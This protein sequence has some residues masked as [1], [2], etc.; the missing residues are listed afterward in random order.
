MKNFIKRFSKF[1]CLALAIL[2]CLSIVGCKPQDVV[3]DEYTY[4][5]TE[6]YPDNNPDLYFNGTH[7]FTAPVIE[8]EWL[9][10]NGKTDYV[11][12]FPADTVEA[13]KTYYQYYMNEFVYLW[14]KATG[15]VPTIVKD[16]E[17]PDGGVHKE[18]TKYISVGNTSLFKS[19]RTEG[20]ETDKT[21]NNTKVALDRVGGRVKLIDNNLYIIGYCDTGTLSAVYSFFQLTFNYQV[22]SSNTIKIDENVT[23][24]KLR[25]YDITDIPDI[26]Y[27]P[28][29]GYEKPNFYL[30][31]NY[32]RT[33]THSTYDAQMYGPRLRAFR[34]GD[35]IIREILPD[36]YDGKIEEAIQA[37]NDGTLK[38]GT[39]S[40]HNS[41]DVVRA[42]K[43]GAKHSDWFMTGNLQLCYST[44]GNEEEFEAL[45][46][47]VADA[48]IMAFMLNPTEQY[49]MTYGV[50]FTCFDDP[51]MCQCD[52]CQIL[53]KS[54]TD[55]GIITRFTNR[56]CEKV[57]AWIELPENAAYYRD[58]WYIMNAAYLTTQQPSV[59]YNA[60]TE[61]WEP[62][63][64]TVV[65]CE[66]VIIEFC[67]GATDYQQSL[68]AAENKWVKDMMDGWSALTKRI[69][70]FHYLNYTRNPN[71][72][73][74]NF[75]FVS[76]K[77][78]N[79]QI[80]GVGNEYYYSETIHGE[81][82]T[83]WGALLSFINGMLCYNSVLDSGKL[84]DAWFK[85]VYG[86]A[87]NVMYGFFNSQRI[88]NH[89]Q[90]LKHDNYKRASNNT[91]I[92]MIYDWSVSVLDNW[93]NQCQSA[94][95]AVEYLKEIDAEEYDRICYN[96]AIERH[97]IVY[98]MFHQFK[99]TLT[100][101][102]YNTYKSMLSE[103]LDRWPEYEFT[104]AGMGTTMLDWFKTI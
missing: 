66:N 97:S 62:V 74:D 15:F 33:Y 51:K 92:D 29:S 10:K 57:R 24:L 86:P 77:D 32:Q 40:G 94:M 30:R 9:I 37:L 31:R 47:K 34:Q 90:T 23:N 36:E 1:L 98:I 41:M 87:A 65:P 69:T 26:L 44:K 11:L 48:A 19:V 12:V 38:I 42:D 54:Y 56:V 2:M 21:I 16:T 52:N 73:Y 96:I 93:I 4:L 101:E 25:D 27:A 17:L 3:V 95:D 55:S 6:L 78:I 67:P 104:H 100:S 22:Y 59:T 49:P 82:A 8:N 99:D 91:S 35:I 103:S 60:G 7:D 80:Y 88:W 76:T 85:A 75:D 72:F 84:M 102:Q 64:E 28:T 70:Y 71:Y 39:T 63:D 68:F 5:D 20:V 14:Q 81:A 45:T 43:W 50:Q 79:Y 53:R 89:E 13:S 83:E 61:S 58:D 18:D 46:S